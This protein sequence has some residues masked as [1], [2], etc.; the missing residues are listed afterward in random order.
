MEFA[1][2]HHRVQT[3]STK[4]LQTNTIYF[5]RLFRG[6]RSNIDR[7]TDAVTVKL[8]QL[9]TSLPQTHCPLVALAITTQ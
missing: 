3:Q 9:I 5:E 8:F 2:K 4:S 1:A 6:R 7:Y